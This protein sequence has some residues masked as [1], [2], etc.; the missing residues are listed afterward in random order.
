LASTVKSVDKWTRFGLIRRKYIAES[1]SKP[2][3]KN[4]NKKYKIS[5]KIGTTLQEKNIVHIS[6]QKYRISTMDKIRKIDNFTQTKD[7][8]QNIA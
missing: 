1:Y 5:V 2:S 8:P 4:A 3:K 7:N 6:I